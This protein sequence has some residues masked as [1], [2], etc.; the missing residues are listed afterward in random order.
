MRGGFSRLILFTSTLSV[1]EM[2]IAADPCL[3]CHSIIKLQVIRIYRRL[4]NLLY[5]KK[6]SKTDGTTR[7]S[8]LLMSLIF[9][10]SSALVDTVL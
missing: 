2:A 8:G 7:D 9:L 1:L 3:Y 5:Q 10:L 6:V 4:S